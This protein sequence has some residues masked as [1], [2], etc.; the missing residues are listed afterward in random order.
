MAKA[1]V[2]VTKEA[3]YAALLKSVDNSDI[4]HQAK[5]IEVY[6]DF[7]CGCFKFKVDHPSI[8]PV[9]DGAYLPIISPM[10]RK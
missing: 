7:D 6:Y 3:I 1:I 9:S 4:L 10:Y 5:L 8:P 2:K